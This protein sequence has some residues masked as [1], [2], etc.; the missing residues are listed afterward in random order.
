MC[1]CQASILQNYDFLPEVNVMITSFEVFLPLSSTNC[2]TWV[3]NRQHCFAKNIFKFI[4]LI[5]GMHF[6][7]TWAIFSVL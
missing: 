3:R 7:L 6:I 2:S 4:T 1:I 5:P